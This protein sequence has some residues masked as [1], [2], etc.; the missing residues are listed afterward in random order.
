MLLGIIIGCDNPEL[1]LI[2]DPSLKCESHYKA[3]VTLKD[4]L[5][6]EERPPSEEEL[7]PSQPG[8]PRDTAS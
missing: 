2:S 3:Q 6:R 4:S 1:F 8:A 7:D 5:L